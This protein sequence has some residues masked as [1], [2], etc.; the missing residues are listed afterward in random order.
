MDE[1]TSN[2]IALLCVE[3]AVRLALHETGRGK[4]AHQIASR[5]EWHLGP[6]F[7]AVPQLREHVDLESV[8]REAMESEEI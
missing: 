3:L 4:E 7:E 5:V 6:L 1:M 2:K 8:I